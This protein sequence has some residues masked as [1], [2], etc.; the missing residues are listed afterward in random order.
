MYNHLIIHVQFL[1]FQIFF[2]L[3][4]IQYTTKSIINTSIFNRSILSPLWKPFLL[5]SKIQVVLFIRYLL[6]LLVL[7]IFFCLILL[8]FHLQ[9]IRM[10]VYK[11]SN[12]LVLQPMFLHLFLLY[13]QVNFRYLYMHIIPLTRFALVL[14]HYSF[15]SCVFRCIK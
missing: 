6:L 15:F 7:Q 3:S 2:L 12:C 4:H 9:L 1:Q 13:F 14:L 8:L 5:H 10:L 11:F